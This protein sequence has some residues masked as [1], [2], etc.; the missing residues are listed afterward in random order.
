MFKSEKFIKQEKL[1]KSAEKKSSDDFFK[2]IGR[3][4]EEYAVE[5]LRKKG[6]K[7]VERNWKARFGEIDIIAKHE[8]QTLIVEV[9][10]RLDSEL[11]REL[12]FCNVDRRKQQKLQNLAECYMYSKVWQF[13]PKQHRFR[14]DA[15]GVIV[16]RRFKLLELIHLKEIA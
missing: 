9:K 10:T 16:D 1:I 11:S 6:A 3:V 15:V 4:G 13:D 12:L 8:D 14:I 7:I 5:H 2:K